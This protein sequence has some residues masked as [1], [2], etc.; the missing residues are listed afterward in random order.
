MDVPEPLEELGDSRTPL[1]P[2][3]WEALAE[4]AGR[5][6]LERSAAWCEWRCHEARHGVVRVDLTLR[7][8]GEGRRRTP[9]SG[10]GALRPMW[11]RRNGGR[12]HGLRD[13]GAA[14]RCAVSCCNRS[15]AAGSSASPRGKCSA[16]RV[17]GP[18]PTGRTS[19]GGRRA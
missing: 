5:M 6:G 2:G 16:G 11:V 17:A 14:R 19:T 8:A 13:V 10:A 9:F 18:S 12:D 3:F 4:A 1:P 15:H 7:P